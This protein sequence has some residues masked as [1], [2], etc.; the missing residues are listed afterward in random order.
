LIHAEVLDVT[1][2]VEIPVTPLM[3]DEMTE[4]NPEHFREVARRRRAHF[5]RHRAMLE[6]LRVA[7][8]LRA[9]DTTVATFGLLALISRVSGWFS[10]DGRLSGK[11]V[12][13]EV[14]K[15]ALG[16]LLPHPTP[17]IAALERSL[18]E[19]V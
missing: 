5:D 12:A 11:E 18:P 2:E 16:A 9:V 17:V 14:T 10:P 4:L 6:A 3:I 13:L 15:L 8:K 7:G 19:P 1:G